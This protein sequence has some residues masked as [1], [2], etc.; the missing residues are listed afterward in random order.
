MLLFSLIVICLLAGLW[1]HWQQR[2]VRMSCSN[3]TMKHVKKLR[4]RQL[5]LVRH[6]DEALAF[7]QAPPPPLLI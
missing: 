7:I 3:T 2:P 1:L 5:P 4:R 6:A